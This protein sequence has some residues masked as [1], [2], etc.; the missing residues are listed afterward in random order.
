MSVM[1]V[2]RGDGLEVLQVRRPGR[3]GRRTGPCSRTAAGWWPCPG[4][5]TTP[6][7]LVPASSRSTAGR[8]PSARYLRTTVPAMVDV[9]DVVEAAEL[10]LE[11]PEPGVVAHP[12]GAEVDQPRL[13]HAAVVV[14]WSGCRPC[15]PTRDPSARAA[16]R[17]G[18]SGR[19]GGRSAGCVDG[20]S[21]PSAQRL[22]RRRGPCPCPT[23]QHT[24]SV[25]VSG[26]FTIGPTASPSSTSSQKRGSAPRRP[27]GGVRG[28]DR[29]RS[30]RRCSGSSS[31]ASYFFFSRAFLR[32]VRIMRRYWP[33]QHRA[34]V[35]AEHV[36]RP[37]V[38]RPPGELAGLV[39]HRH[40]GVAAPDPVVGPQRRPPLPRRSPSRTRARPAAGR[41]SS[42]RAGPRGP[43]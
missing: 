12:V 31:M 18:R 11:L 30:P 34:V 32:S 6:R 43:R 9:A 33:R 1:R 38:H 42:G 41:P 27:L 35:V 7:W 23:C 8:S 10:A 37:L 19:R 22:A 26:P 3:S 4:V 13:A 29:R 39:E 40:Q 20:S 16:S 36:R 14:T 24:M 17:R 15:G 5:V 25:T 28:V 21:T 2:A